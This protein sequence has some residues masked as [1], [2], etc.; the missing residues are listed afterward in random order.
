MFW[1]A[2][3]K[4]NRFFQDGKKPVE[5][6]KVVFVECWLYRSNL[7]GLKKWAGGRR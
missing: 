3:E 7:V 1:I 2:S 4:D 6:R 5:Q